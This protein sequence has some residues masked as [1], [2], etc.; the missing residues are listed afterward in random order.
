MGRDLGRVPTRSPGPLTS[1]LLVSSF[2]A[3][4][5]VAGPAWADPTPTPAPTPS[6]SPPSQQQIDDAREA[7]ERLRDQGE[8][9]PVEAPT[10]TTLAQV[11]GPTAGR[12]RESVAPRLGDQAW[13]TIGAG[14]LVLVVI[15]ETTRLSVRRAKH[16][17]A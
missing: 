11:S 14:L 4:L 6:L 7:L 12:D 1:A 15:S 17:K 2:L 3:A 9:T 13:W 8:A 10:P 16:R 5:V